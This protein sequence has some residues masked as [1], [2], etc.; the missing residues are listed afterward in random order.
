MSDNDYNN[1]E[2][3]AAA[4]RSVL[5]KNSAKLKRDPAGK[6]VIEKT[7]EFVTQVEISMHIHNVYVDTG[8]SYDAKPLLA[9]SFRSIHETLAFRNVPLIIGGGTLGMIIGEKIVSIS[10]SVQWILIAVGL[11]IGIGVASLKSDVSPADRS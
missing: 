3:S 6:E 9:F 2:R 1:I 10:S 4:L 7:E 8:W 5:R 11:L